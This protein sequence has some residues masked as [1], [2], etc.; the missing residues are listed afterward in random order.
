MDEEELSDMLDEERE[1]Y[2][3]KIEEKWAIRIPAKEFK[4]TLLEDLE[5]DIGLLES[6]Y[7]MWFGEDVIYEDPKFDKFK[8]LISG[9]M[10]KEP[11]RKI[12]VFSEFA[13]TT[14]AIYE[15]AKKSGLRVMKY[16]SADSSLVNKEIIKANFD[17]S[18]KGAAQDD[19]DILIATDAISEWYNLH[20]AGII[21]NYDIPFNPTRVIQRIGR[22][23]RVNKK[24][25]DD[26]YIYNFFPTDIGE[27]ETQIKAIST[28]KMHMI[29]ALLGDDAKALTDDEILH[30]YFAEDYKRAEEKD[31]AEKEWWWQ[32]KHRNVWESVKN[33]VKNYAY[34]HKYQTPCSYSRSIANDIATVSFARRGNT[35]IFGIADGSGIIRLSW[36]EK[37]LD[38]FVS[39]E[40]E[41]L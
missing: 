38:Y 6:V 12:I 31:N 37:T 20:R 15:E 35:P 25:F 19:F 5:H 8:Q 7:D 2:F 21:I 32:K 40:N 30:N 33:D 22:I 34:S 26:L 14:N 3:A 23:N 27:D 41:K 24:V 9:H 29:Q 11:D 39:L 13:D 17:A 10:A 28:L 36:P 18:Y 16:T 4:S 1:T